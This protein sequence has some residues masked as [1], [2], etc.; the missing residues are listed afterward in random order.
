[1]IPTWADEWMLVFI[2]VF[3]VSLHATSVS[4]SVLT[5]SRGSACGSLYEFYNKSH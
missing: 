3:F 5:T 4:L 2:L 1:M